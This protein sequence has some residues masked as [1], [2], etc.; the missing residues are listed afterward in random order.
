L[1]RR[2]VGK[3]MG[4]LLILFMPFHLGGSQTNEAGLNNLPIVNLGESAETKKWYLLD[5]YGDKAILINKVQG[6]NNFKIV[7]MKDINFIENRSK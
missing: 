4:L 2:T 5:K 7:E 1:Y 3:M 6:K